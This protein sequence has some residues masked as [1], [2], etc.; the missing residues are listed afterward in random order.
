[1]DEVQQPSVATKLTAYIRQNHPR[2]VPQYELTVAI[3]SPTTASEI[4]AA[5]TQLV[6]SRT[7]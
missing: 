5:L 4:S 1:M 6:E 7:L 2:P 3:P